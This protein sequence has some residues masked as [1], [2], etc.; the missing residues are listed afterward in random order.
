[1]FPWRELHYYQTILLYFLQESRNTAVVNVGANKA[2]IFL[3]LIP[4]FASIFAVLFLGEQLMWY[5]TAGGIFVIL[6]VYLSAKS[7]SDKSAA[8]QRKEF[9]G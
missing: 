7:V 6:G 3:N 2:G 1:M 4:V 5:Q 8:L 9:F